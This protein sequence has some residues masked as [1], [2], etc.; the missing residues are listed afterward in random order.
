VTKRADEDSNIIL[1]TAFGGNGG[2][3]QSILSG[4]LTTALVLE[5]TDDTDA[6][7]LMSEL[8]RTQMPLS[9]LPRFALGFAGTFVKN[10]F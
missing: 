4:R 8:E 9:I 6:H 7:H 1:N 5:K 10:F 3:N 2:V